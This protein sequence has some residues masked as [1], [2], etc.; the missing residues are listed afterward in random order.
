MIERHDAEWEF[1]EW[2]AD[3]WLAKRIGMD[4]EAGDSAVRERNQADYRA[5]K[6]GFIAAWNRRAE[7]EQPGGEISLERAV[8]VL[9]DRKHDGFKTWAAKRTNDNRAFYVGTILNERML[10]AFEAIA[11]ARAYLRDSEPTG[12][13]GLVQGA[14]AYQDMVGRVFGEPA[15][16]SVADRLPEAYVTV[17][18][19]DEGG[20]V[21]KGRLETGGKNDGYFTDHYYPIMWKAT[22]WQPLPAP[23]EAAE[24]KE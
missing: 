8:E 20:E 9:R 13:A 23:P 5:L 21:Q 6:A 24:V 17:L 16:I 12:L 10:T 2:M 3:E 4:P 15:W 1:K 11:I 22:H 19:V 18:I 7:R 14:T